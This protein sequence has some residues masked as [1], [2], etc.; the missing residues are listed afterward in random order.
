MGTELDIL[1]RRFEREKNARKRA[2]KILEKK[3]LELYHANKKL[4]KSNSEL[5]ARV[6]ERT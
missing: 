2:E 1:K 3:S 6:I 5:E 4:I